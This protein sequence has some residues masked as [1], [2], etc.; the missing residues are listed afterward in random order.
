MPRPCVR[1]CPI[2]LNWCWPRPVALADDVLDALKR[3]LAQS[4][5]E[6]AATS[7]AMPSM[8]RSRCLLADARR[9]ARRW[10]RNCVAWCFTAVPRTWPR[11][12]RCGSRTCASST[13]ARSRSISSWRWRARRSFAPRT[14]CCRCSTRWSAPCWAGAPSSRAQPAQAR[15]LRAGPARD[16]D[17]LGAGRRRAHGPAAPSRRSRWVSVCASCTARPAN[18]CARRACSRSSCRRAVRATAPRCVPARRR[19]RSNARCRRSTSCAD[20]LAGE[21]PGAGRRRCAA[22]LHP[23]RARSAGGAAGPQAGGADDAAPGRAFGAPV[24]AGQVGRGRQLHC[25]A[26]SPDRRSTTSRSARCWARRSSA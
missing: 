1:H 24:G 7:L 2:A 12:S 14:T 19:P 9:C 5:G 26:P 21:P 20:C 4:E 17:G 23:H 8:P 22:R 11:T 25:H 10:A 3:Q 18:G 16:A 6:P 15:G 13:S